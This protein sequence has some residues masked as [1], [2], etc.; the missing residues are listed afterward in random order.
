MGIASFPP[1]PSSVRVGVPRHHTWSEPSPTFP[2]PARSAQPT[3]ARPCM[4]AA[5]MGRAHD[6]AQ[7]HPPAGGLRPD[8]VGGR[9]CRTEGTPGVQGTHLPGRYWATARWEENRAPLSIVLLHPLKMPT[10]PVFHDARRCVVL[11][12]HRCVRPVLG[13]RALSPGPGG[14]VTQSLEPPLAKGTGDLSHASQVACALGSAICSFLRLA[15]ISLLTCFL[16]PARRARWPCLISPSWCG[17]HASCC[18]SSVSFGGHP[19]LC[20][21]PRCFY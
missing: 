10:P 21:S 17:R 3:W 12:E 11:C 19:T 15:P 9:L 14:R 2:L 16:C 8:I 1:P 18:F 7:V 20:S 6:R 5:W 4:R 13:V